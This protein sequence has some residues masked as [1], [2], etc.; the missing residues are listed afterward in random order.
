[1][2]LPIPV[3]ISSALTIMD[4][5]IFLPHFLHSCGRTD[6]PCGAGLSGLSKVMYWSFRHTPWYWLWKNI[7]FFSYLFSFQ[8]QKTNCYHSRNEDVYRIHTIR[9]YVSWCLFSQLCHLL[10]PAWKKLTGLFLISLVGVFNLLQ[11]HFTQPENQMPPRNA[12]LSKTICR[13]NYWKSKRGRHDAIS[14]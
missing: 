12:L 14:M 1:M 11:D 9:K 8:T 2:N 4:K 13:K 3:S 10:F 5:L 6:D 7:I